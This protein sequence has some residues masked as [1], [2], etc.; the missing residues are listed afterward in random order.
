MRSGGRS[1]GGVSEQGRRF[2]RREHDFP[3]PTGKDERAERRGDLPV[4]RHEGG[5]TW[6]HIGNP[7]LDR[8]AKKDR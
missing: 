7:G 6:V 4:R 1:S 5:E 2:M 8:L 3:Q